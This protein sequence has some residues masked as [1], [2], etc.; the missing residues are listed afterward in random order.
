MFKKRD[1]GSGRKRALT[2]SGLAAAIGSVL[3]FWRR[4]RSS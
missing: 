2:L 1:K 4:R 3:F